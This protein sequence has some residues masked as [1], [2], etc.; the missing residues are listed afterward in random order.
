MNAAYYKEYSHELNREME[1]KVFGHAGKPCLVFPAQNGR[2]F[3]YENFGM[4]NA[5]KDYIDAGRIQLFC[6][7]SVDAETWSFETGNPRQRI[8]QHERY[9]H[10]I[11]DELVPRIHEISAAGITKEQ[12][13]MTTGC[14][15]GAFHALNF[16]LRRP[17]LFDKVIAL[18]GIYH[19][20]FFFQDYHD[21]LT[22]V[23]SPSDYLPNLPEDHRFMELYRRSEVILCCGRG[24]WEQ[25]MEDSLHTMEEIFHEKKIDLWVDYWGYDVSHDW[26]WWKKQMDYFLQFVV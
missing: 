15:M 6:C 21:E 10:Y 3:D 18:S 20:D 1:F 11:L 17:D 14:S 9:V 7:D 16:F 2:F 26:Y 8:E 23:N 19:A 13:I 5:I 12:L 4:V 24:A 25:E 22:Y